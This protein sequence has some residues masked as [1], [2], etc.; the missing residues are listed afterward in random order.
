MQSIYLTKR[1]SSYKDF[2][3]TIHFGQ[4]PK[5]DVP[6]GSVLVKVESF[7]ISIDDVHLS[8][9]S[10]IGGIS[11]LQSRSP[12]E[13]KP[14]VIGVDYAG[15]VED[16]SNASFESLE[17]YGIKVGTR[18]CG[19]S[20]IFRGQ[21]GTWAEYTAAK[22]EKLTVI[23]DNISFVE[24]SALVMPL[25]VSSSLLEEGNI[26]KRSETKNNLK[27]LVI[28]AS[29]GIGSLCLK[30]LKAIDADIEVTGVC[31]SRNL[32]FVKSLGVAS[33]LDYT[34]GEIS[35]QTDEKYDVILDCV[36]GDEYYQEA[37]KMAAKGSVFVTTTGPVRWLGERILSTF[38][39]TKFFGYV[40]WKF[41]MNLIPWNKMKFAFAG[42]KS[43]MVIKQAFKEVSELGIRATIEEVVGFNQE[44]LNPT[45]EKL[46]GHKISGRVVCDL[47]KK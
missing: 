7:S 11:K 36:G 25:F 10:F 13:E 2:T 43:E 6:E 19:I 29:G 37:Y 35:K 3:S 12:T 46:V 45:F 31:S 22:V 39:L 34:K 27:V 26:R 1:P 33:V 44:E 32:D 38:E 15:V 5:P 17:K 28:G 18:V 21:P 4:Q 42:T 24:A 47:S 8:M 40:G 30:R 41:A 14:L 9:G 23:P 20:T 16:V